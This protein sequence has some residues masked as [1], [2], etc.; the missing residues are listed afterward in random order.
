MITPISLKDM[1]EAEF[2]MTRT[3]RESRLKLKEWIETKDGRIF[4]VTGEGETFYTGREV[5]Y[6]LDTPKLYYGNL[7]TIDKGEVI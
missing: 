5:L 6:M 2:Y 1:T 4:E 3:I 7:E